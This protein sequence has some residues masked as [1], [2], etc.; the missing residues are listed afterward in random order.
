MEQLIP[1]RFL[2]LALALALSRAP[3][4]TRVPSQII[5]QLQDVFATVG[6]V[7]SS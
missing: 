4:I 6:A 5:S 1:V 3:L 7:H 2:C